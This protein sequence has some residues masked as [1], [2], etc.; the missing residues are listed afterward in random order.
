MFTS[1]VQSRAF[2]GIIYP[3]HWTSCIITC[4]ALDTWRLLIR[5]KIGTANSDMLMFV[6]ETNISLLLCR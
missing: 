2:F 5:T 1:F 6:T 3:V 4:L